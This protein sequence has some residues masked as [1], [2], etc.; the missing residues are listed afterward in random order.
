M[1]RMRAVIC[2]QGDLSVADIDTPVPDKGQLLVEVQRCGICGSDLHARVHGDELGK[3]MVETG[4]DDFMR[5]DQKIVFGHEL[6]GVVADHG[7]GTGKKLSVGTPVVSIPLLRNPGTVDALG[8]SAKA[9]GAY[10]DYLV[11]QEHLTLKVPNG[12]AADV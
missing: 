4:Y 1:V 10:A 8:L 11:T 5:S 3:V 12:L 9:P 2:H 7:P 6:Y